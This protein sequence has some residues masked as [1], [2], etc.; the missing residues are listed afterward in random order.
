MFLQMLD[1]RSAADEQHVR[2]AVQQPEARDLTACGREDHGKRREHP[3]AKNS[4][5]TSP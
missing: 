3:A 1:Q 5:T 2:G 4:T